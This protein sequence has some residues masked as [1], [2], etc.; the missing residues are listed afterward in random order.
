MNYDYEVIDNTN[1]SHHNH[2]PYCFFALNHDLNSLI[3][4]QASIDLSVE[5]TLNREHFP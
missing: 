2:S 3:I 1:S 5:N 4:S